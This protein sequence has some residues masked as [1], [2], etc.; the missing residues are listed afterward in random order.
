MD[1]LCELP[2]REGVDEKRR[3]DI[4]GFDIEIIVD[5]FYIWSE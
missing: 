4:K 5:L 1:L 3:V 2:I